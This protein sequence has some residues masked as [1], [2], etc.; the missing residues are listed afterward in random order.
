MLIDLHALWLSLA[1]NKFVYIM[2]RF[3]KVRVSVFIF[4]S[5][6]QDISIYHLIL[7]RF[8]SIQHTRFALTYRDFVP[9]EILFVL[10]F[11]LCHSYKMMSEIRTTLFMNLFVWKFKCKSKKIELYLSKLMHWHTFLFQKSILL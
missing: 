7:K 8:I 2:L 9:R 11:M 3:A 4:I 1:T 6:Y 5:H 10:K